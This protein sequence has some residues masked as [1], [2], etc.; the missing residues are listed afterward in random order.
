[1]TEAR[2]EQEAVERNDELELHKETLE[3]LTPEDEAGGAVKGGGAS[4]YG[5]TGG[6]HA[7]GG[8]GGAG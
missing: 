6:C 2:D 3:D 5:C 4:G 1:M 7:A 8:G